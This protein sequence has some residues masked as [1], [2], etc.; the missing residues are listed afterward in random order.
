MK[1]RF[2]LI[3]GLIMIFMLLTGCGK[4]IE[5]T[6]EESD[7]ISQYAASLLLKYDVN[8]ENALKE[9]TQK[10]EIEEPDNTEEVITPEEETLT[11]EEQTSEEVE[12]SEGI[13]EENNAKSSLAEVFGMDGIQVTYNGCEFVKSYPN[14]GNSS[15]GFRMTAENGRKL[16][17]IKFV[18]TNTS[19]EI[20]RCDVL[21]GIPTFKATINGTSVPARMTILLEDLSTTC[22]DVEPGA[23]V[24]KV[25][26][27]QVD[28]G[29]AE[30]I[31]SL[32]LLVTFNKVISTV[33][34]LP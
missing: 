34:L 11:E 25:L 27:C 21:S 5:L 13:T 20:K 29:M 22:E 17:I 24:E 10:P 28:E 16:A 8:Y 2:V 4:N 1:K 9:Q 31:E 30:N 6:E 18:I 12:N 3:G 19:G 32:E 26:I 14:K 23:S 7:I 15:S 33:V